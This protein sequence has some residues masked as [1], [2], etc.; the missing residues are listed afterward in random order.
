MIYG[1]NQQKESYLP[2]IAR[3]EVRWGLGFSEPDAGSDL[4]GLRTRAVAD[5]DEFVINGSKVWNHSTDVDLLQLLARTNP[6]APKH[7]G[8][9]QFIMPLQNTP[10]VTIE[11]ILDLTGQDRWTLVTFEDVRLPRSAVIGEVD[12]GWYQQTTSLDLERAQMGW[13]GESRRNFEDLL[14]LAK[15]LSKN[16][17]P[18]LHDPYVRD[19]LGELAIAMETARWIA[20]RVAYQQDQGLIPNAEASM[21]KLLTSEVQQRLQRTGMDLL[22]PNGFYTSGSPWA[23]A[24]G[25]WDLEFWEA[26]GT[27]I[28]GG[29]SEIQRNIIAT[30]GLG[31]PR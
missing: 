1:T 31:L 19:R 18:I 23:V 21:C 9:T 30:R 26:I 13:L 2:L 27:T 28:A 5:G 20:F 25:V 11:V 15:T 6:D 24:D 4:A 29:T 22:G 7:K 12:R 16:G 17:K 3:G 8:I 10:G 14:T